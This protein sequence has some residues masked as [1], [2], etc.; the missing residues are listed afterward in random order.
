MKAPLLLFTIFLGIVLA[1]HLAM[2]GKV[3]ASLNN[4]TRR[5]WALLVYRSASR[6]DHRRHRLEIRRARR[7]ER[8]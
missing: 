5:Q 6:C 3:G 4:R 8:R 1:V 2:N 7:P